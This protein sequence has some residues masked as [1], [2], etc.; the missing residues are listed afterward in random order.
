M[1]KHANKSQRGAALVEAAMVIPLI[2]V[3]LI[4]TIEFGLS[5]A[6]LI[7][8][9]QGVRDGTRNAVVDN[10]GTDTS[11]GLTGAAA[12]A[13]DGSKTVI[14]GTKNEIAR[15]ES[16]VAVKLTFPD[17]DKTPQP[18]DNSLLVCAEFQH[19]SPTGMFGFILDSRV[20]T[21][22]VSM[23]IEQDLSAVDAVEETSLSGSWAWCS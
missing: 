18:D 11:C 1:R 23:R 12:T 9:R 5:L 19:R 20:S 2:I 8:V 22:R 4:G 14:C 21:T 13:V 6:D 10:Y 15:P 17:T 7:S 3:I 16:R